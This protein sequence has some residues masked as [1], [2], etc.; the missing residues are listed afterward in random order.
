[1]C[2]K[3][4]V[5]LAKVKTQCVAKKN[6]RGSSMPLLGGRWPLARPANKLGQFM[7]TF[8]LDYV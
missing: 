3:A 5:D 1:M 2:V 6:H 8:H 4:S 7:A